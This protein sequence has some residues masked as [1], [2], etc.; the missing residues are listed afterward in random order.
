MQIFGKENSVDPD[1]TALVEPVLSGSALFAQTCLSK[2]LGSLRYAHLH[3][4]LT[5]NMVHMYNYLIS[6]SLS[7]P[8]THYFTFLLF[9]TEI[10]LNQQNIYVQK[11]VVRTDTQLAV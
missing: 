1:Q 10:L 3:F 9:Y 7:N 4:G 2:N 8:V 5:L 6:V 11:V